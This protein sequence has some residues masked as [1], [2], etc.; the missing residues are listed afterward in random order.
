MKQDSRVRDTWGTAA[1][2]LLARERERAGSTHLTSPTYP[3]AQIG[4]AFAPCCPDRE[5]GGPAPSDQQREPGPRPGT[6][7]R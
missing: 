5:P 1:K 6:R 3:E 2:L 7:P 4:D